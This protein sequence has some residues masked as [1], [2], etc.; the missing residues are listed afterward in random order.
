MALSS[1][2]LINNFEMYFDGTDMTNASLYLCIDSSV[3]AIIQILSHQT[4][5]VMAVLS[6]KT[7]P[8]HCFVAIQKLDLPSRHSKAN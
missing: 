5:C 6:S 4:M 1:T 3:F 8:K 7:N 2:D